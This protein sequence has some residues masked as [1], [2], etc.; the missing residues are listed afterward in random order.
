MWRECRNC[1]YK[2]ARQLFA[3]V[4]K[5]WVFFSNPLSTVHSQDPCWASKLTYS[6]IPTTEMQPVAHFQLAQVALILLI[7][8]VS[9]VLPMKDVSVKLINLVPARPICWE[10]VKS[11]TSIL[12]YSWSWFRLYFLCVLLLMSWEKRSCASEPNKTGLHRC[13]T[14]PVISFIETCFS[15]M[16]ALSGCVSYAVL[17]ISQEMRI[18]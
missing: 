3:S 5:L 2:T 7:Q 6:N 12:S 18:V 13:L 17:T 16:E 10:H 11:H 14:G 15:T 8:T 4:C 1:T 9:G